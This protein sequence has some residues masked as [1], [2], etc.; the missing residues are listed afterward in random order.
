M[1]KK[2][3]FEG[4]HAEM[5]QDWLDTGSSSVLPNEIV[6]Y[7]QQLDVVRGWFNAQKPKNSILKLLQVHYPR[8]TGVTAKSRYNDALNYFWLDNQVKKESW[9][10]I[11]A[12]LLDELRKATIMSAKSPQDYKIAKEMIMDA[13]KVRG[14]FDPKEKELPQELFDKPIKIYTMVPED[15]GLES[16]NRNLLAQQIEMFALEESQ[17]L[18]IKKD[19][20]LAQKTLFNYEQENED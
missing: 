14:V 8:L 16:A 18:E 20:G 15:V 19:A 13:A 17:K 1:S 2:Y 9:R 5:L 3:E 7:L 4:L 6:E 12:D 11:Y 10:N